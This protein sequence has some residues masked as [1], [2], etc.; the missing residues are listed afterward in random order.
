MKK[1]VQIVCLAVMGLA[2]YSVCVFAQVP[3]HPQG[4]TPE[5]PW[6]LLERELG[7]ETSYSVDIT[8]QAMG[9]TMDMHMARH[10]HKTRTEM[11]MP[12]INL[13]SVILNIPEGGHSVS[14]TLFPDK[15]KYVRD[16]IENASLA[17]T[18]APTIEDLGTETYQGEVCS[19]R[20][21]VVSQGGM[22]SEM[23]MLT[24]PK[25]KNMPVTIT[26]TMDAPGM[27]G[28][29]NVPI[30]T[31]MIFKNYNFATPAD[32]L[33]VIPADYVQVANMQAVMMES[34]PDLGEL[35]KQFQPMQP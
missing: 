7:L 15:K 19:K 33:F 8:M 13:K 11:V 22:K 12:L 2:G 34:L 9:M 28:N 3:G 31:T 26:M 29:A 25:Q 32:R 21:V 20:R 24:S 16:E 6:L 1:I 5:Q 4:S 14:Y 30:Q 17:A 23:I 35:M 10:N 18:S 27:A